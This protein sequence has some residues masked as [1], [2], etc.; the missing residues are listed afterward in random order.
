MKTPSATSLVVVITAAYLVSSL[1]ITF[2]QVGTAVRGIRQL[3]TLPQAEIDGCI[4]AYKFFQ[5]R[6]DGTATQ[7]GSTDEET[8]HVR[9]YY[10][11]LNYVLAV[12][13]VRATRDDCQLLSS[14]THQ[15]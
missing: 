8:E 14:F 15:A 12:A 1:D 4:A 7:G 3:F 11:V 5:S 10:T 9:A 6:Q 13:D 2:Y